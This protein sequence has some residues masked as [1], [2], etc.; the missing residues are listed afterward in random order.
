MLKLRLLVTEKCLKNCEGCCNKD[1]DLKS[2]PIF[3]LNDSTMF[4]EIMITGGE[5][6]LFP[7]KVISLISSIRYTGFDKNIYM[8]TAKTSSFL[9]LLSVLYLLDGITI[10]L[11]DKQDLE[12]FNSFYVIWNTIRNNNKTF[13]LNVFKEAELPKDWNFAGWKIK[14]DMEWIKNCPL[15]KDEVFMRML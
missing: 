5:P 9:P 7:G 4:D 15:P 11:H 6:L 14:R 2:L 3:D 8:Y 1:W 13:R 12:D 10:T